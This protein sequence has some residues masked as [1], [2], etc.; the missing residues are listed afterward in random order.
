MISGSFCSGLKS[1]V[2]Q[3]RECNWPAR[4]PGRFESE[5]RSTS[6]GI[7]GRLS[8]CAL[9]RRRTTRFRV[10]W[11]VNTS[12]G[13]LVSGGG[14]VWVVARSEQV[15]TGGAREQSRWREAIGDGVGGAR[16]LATEF[17]GRSRAVSCRTKRG[18]KAQERRWGTGSSRKTASSK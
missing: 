17:G 13:A 6:V 15:P 1:R 9:G 12:A 4:N 10:C 3:R 5:L 18:R 2:D 7:I 11:A 8:G 14:E 16:P